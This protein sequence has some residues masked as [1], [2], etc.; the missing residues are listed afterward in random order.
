MLLLS[1]AAKTSIK[2]LQQSARACL[3][4]QDYMSSAMTLSFAFNN[5]V[6]GWRHMLYNKQQ[7][8]SKI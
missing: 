5:K 7:L 2:A 3:A 1:Y 6:P 8:Y 4:S